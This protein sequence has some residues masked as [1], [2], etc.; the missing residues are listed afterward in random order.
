MY[1]LELINVE[2]IKE[3]E[4]HIPDRVIWLT[5]LIKKEKIW[6][7]PIL[8]DKT[9][10][11]I[12]DGHHRYNVAKN[13]GLKRIPAILL[14]YNSPNVIVT[15]WRDDIFIDKDVVLEYINRGAIFPNKTTRHIIKPLPKE[16]EIPISFLY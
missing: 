11:A 3:T 12:M 4:E 10:Y 14:S 16:I 13:L 6:R 7:V 8:L 9:T 5:E 2:S 1:R 15:S